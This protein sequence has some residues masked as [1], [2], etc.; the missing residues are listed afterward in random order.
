MFD[1]LKKIKIS[2]IIKVIRE[3]DFN[4]LT[5]SQIKKILRALGILFCIYVYYA[6]RTGYIPESRSFQDK[7]ALR[8]QKV[9]PASPR[10]SDSFTTSETTVDRVSPTDLLPSPQEADIPNTRYDYEHQAKNTNIVAFQPFNE[11]KH[12]RHYWEYKA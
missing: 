5:E 12:K 2:H 9:E 8:Q 10:S 6:T 11:Q 1:K 7:S 4:N 3:F